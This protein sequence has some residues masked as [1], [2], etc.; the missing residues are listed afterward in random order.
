MH[1]KLSLIVI[2]LL[3]CGRLFSQN[4]TT[5][6]GNN[7][8]NGQSALPGPQQVTAPEWTVTDA[9]TTALG[10]N[11]YSFGDRF[12]TSRVDFSP[13]TAL[14][15]CRDLA[16]GELIWM[17]PGLS[18]GSIMYVMGF[19]EDAVYA[20]DYGTGSFYALHPSDGSVKWEY[21]TSYTFGP[22]DGVI[23][24]CDRNIII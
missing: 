7:E 16:T 11:I 1:R 13:Y 19:N 5:H 23:Y 6:C 8:R 10:M 4:W 22:M 18:P 2:V 15:E 3:A 12:V 9:M 17:Q 14:I 24:T 20:H 21:N